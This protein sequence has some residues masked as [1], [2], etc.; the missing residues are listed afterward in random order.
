[1]SIDSFRRFFISQE[2]EI[3]NRLQTRLMVEYL[4]E[5]IN[6]NQWKEQILNPYGSLNLTQPLFGFP[7]GRADKTKW[8]KA[9]SFTLDNPVPDVAIVDKVVEM[10]CSP[11]A[12][13]SK[14]QHFNCKKK[15]VGIHPSVLTRTDILTT[16]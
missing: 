5:K 16:G 8:N 13:H 10:I 7:S 14:C 2:G 6:T 1:M 12:Q 4:K 3:T 15:D 11:D 9:V